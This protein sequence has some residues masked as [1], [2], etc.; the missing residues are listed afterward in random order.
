MYELT[1]LSFNLGGIF[2]DL[3][4]LALNSFD[5]LQNCSAVGGS[6]R[7][8]NLAKSII[9]GE[10][11]NLFHWLWYLLFNEFDNRKVIAS[12]VRLPMVLGKKYQSYICH[13]K[14]IICNKQNINQWA[15][16]N[17]D[18][19]SVSGGSWNPGTSMVFQEGV[20]LTGH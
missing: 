15:L 20:V 19:F 14:L 18:K 7:P 16:I 17:S 11:D 9:I 8:K 13:I 1:C 4:C 6:P 5:P 10:P 12:S 3:D 2:L